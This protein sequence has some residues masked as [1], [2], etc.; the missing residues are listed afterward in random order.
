MKYKNLLIFFSAP[1]FTS[2][3][4]ASHAQETEASPYRDF[5][6]Q[7]PSE[8]TC[9]IVAHLDKEGLL[10][11]DE[12]T[13]KLRY[14]ETAWHTLIQNEF[15]QLKYLSALDYPDDLISYKHLYHLLKYSYLSRGFYERC[16]LYQDE[17][18]LWFLEHAFSLRKFNYLRGRL[19]KI[20]G[21]TEQAWVYYQ[22]SAHA[23]FK[24][25]QKVVAD[26]LYTGSFGQSQR[27]EVERFKELRRQADLGNIYAQRMF[28]EAIYK[29]RLGQGEVSENARWRRLE[30]WAKLGDDYAKK[31]IVEAIYT[32][33]LGQKDEPEDVRFNELKLLAYDGNQYAQARVVDA[34]YTGELD[35]KK[36]TEEARFNKLQSLAYQGNK[37]AHKMV[38]NAIF[39]GTLGQDR[40]EM[41]ERFEELENLAYKGD[42]VAL[43]YL[44]RAIRAGSLPPCKD[45]EFKFLKVLADQGNKDAQN[46]IISA[47]FLGKLDQ[48]KRSQSERLQELRKYAE[49]GEK[50]AQEFLV[51]AVGQ[52][53]MFSADILGSKAERFRE[54]FNY[55]LKGYPQAAGYFR[56]A[57]IRGVKDRQSVSKKERAKE[58]A[59]EAREQVLFLQ[60]QE[61][62]DLST[63]NLGDILKQAEPSIASYFEFLDDIKNIS[64]PEN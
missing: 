12:A 19:E 36:D 9:K 30:F 13:V 56:S 31:A 52:G 35:Q 32:G 54:L 22:Q 61:E 21:N 26:A 64:K 25:A 55:A 58:R 14:T 34:I 24:P 5:L 29:G 23:A 11:L 60:L 3:F 63:A 46:E 53:A 6:A 44:I 43:K 48:H 7:L 1:L 42:T 4:I 38:V 20:A 59:K 15:S 62:K 39:G 28:I 37:Y 45:K 49:A 47:V 17:Q 8:L 57:V 18:F 51:I 10:K 27:S 2:Q 40:R 50:V 41:I 16:T 33:Q